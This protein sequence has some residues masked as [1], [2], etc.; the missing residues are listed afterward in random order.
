[1]ARIVTAETRLKAAVI[2][3]LF[4]AAHVDADSVLISEM[5]I[6]NWTRRA[7]IVLANGR[8]WAFELK[9]E[10]DSLTRL[11]GQLEAFSYHFEKLVVVVAARFEVQASKMLP[12]GVG[13]W[14]EDRPGQLKERVRPKILPLAKEAAIQLMTASELRRLLSCNGMSGLKS[15]PRL[16]LEKLAFGLPER[17]IANAARAAVKQRFRSRHAAFVKKRDGVGTLSAIHVL[18]RYANKS[19]QVPEPSLPIDLPAVMLASD[20]PLLVQAPAGPVLRRAR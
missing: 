11:P 15:T 1:M 9:S 6:A 7:D 13:L 4:D 17:D 8:L 14:V 5:A 19:G 3:R 12:D 16:E 10:V 2:D 18:R 20:H